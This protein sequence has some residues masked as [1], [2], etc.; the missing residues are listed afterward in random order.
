MTCHDYREA[1]SVWYDGE[2]AG[3]DFTTLLA[4]VHACTACREYMARLPR[5]AALLRRY[6]VPAGD[7]PG[8]SALSEQK[9]FTGYRLN[10][11]L[12]VAAAI[13]LVIL[14]VAIQGNLQGRPAY[15]PGYSDRGARSSLPVEGR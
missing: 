15:D 12:A 3:M 11:P 9:R 10:A 2:Q 8:A 4:H 13:I 6:P 14:T 7:A 1:T 5:Q